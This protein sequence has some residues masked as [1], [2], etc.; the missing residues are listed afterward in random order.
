MIYIG[1]SVQF[2]ATGGGTMRWGGDNPQVATVDQTTGRITGVS[3]GRVTVWAENEGGRTTRLLRGLP[4]YAG[5]WQGNWVI[6]GCTANGAF[7]ILDLCDDFRNG[8][9]RSL[10]LSLTQTDDRV[11]GGNIVFGSLTGSTTAAT[12]GEDGQVRMTGSLNPLTGN[13]IRIEVENIVLSSQSAG[14][15]QG[16]LEQVWGSTDFSGTMRIYARIANLTRS[17]GGPALQGPPPTGRTAQDL[18]RLL[19]PMR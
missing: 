19:G 2:A 7:A 17:S 1:Q 16:S 12:I 8:G 9:S 6:D 3:N 4:S 15:I 13:S 14:N 5:S 11:S 10:G 18:I